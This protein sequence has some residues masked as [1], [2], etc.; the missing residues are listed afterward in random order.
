MYNVIYYTS[1]CVC[2]CVSSY[3]YSP[4]SVSI[5]ALYSH[6]GNDSYRNGRRERGGR[7]R[8]S[9]EEMISIRGGRERESKKR[10]NKR[11]KRELVSCIAQLHIH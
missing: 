7:E 6:T 5:T 10:S 2:V 8:G 9:G 3:L 4:S 1:M 11:D